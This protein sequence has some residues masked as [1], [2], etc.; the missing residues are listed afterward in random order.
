V[1]TL[2]H[3]AEAMCMAGSLAF[4]TAP[5]LANAC[6]P[7]DDFSKHLEMNYQE[8]VG[9]VGVANDGS[10]FEIFVSDKG[11]WSLLIT[12]GKK[13]SCIVAAGEMWVP[14]SALGAE[15]RVQ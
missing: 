14:S 4:L 5:V 10:L 15:A 13:I 6:A 8:K 11:T 3:F 1:K 7:H 2:N 9:G 12:N